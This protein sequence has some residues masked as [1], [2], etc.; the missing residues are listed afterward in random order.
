MLLLA[1]GAVL[2]LSRDLADPAG[3]PVAVAAGG[4]V[5]LLALLA[6]TPSARPTTRSPTLTSAA[7]SLQNLFPET[8]I[9]LLVT[10]TTAIGMFSAR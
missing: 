4:F 6:L 5:A 10:L 9:R 1:L 8:P 7:V 2:L 3:L